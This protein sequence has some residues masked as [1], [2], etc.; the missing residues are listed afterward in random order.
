MPAKPAQPAAKKAAR[1]RPVTKPPTIAFEVLP[2]GTGSQHTATEAERQAFAALVATGST[3][4]AAYLAVRPK[5]TEVTAN[6]M[7]AKWAAELADQIQAMRQAAQTG[8]A[9]ALGVTQAYLVG[10]VKAMLETPLAQITADSIYC[11]KYKVTTTSTDAGPKTTVEVE[12]PCPLATVQA[13]AKL[14]GQA[15]PLP[16]T[17]Q[18]NAQDA[19]AQAEQAA[20]GRVLARIVSAGSPIARRLAERGGTDTEKAGG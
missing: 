15:E 4:K 9:L 5:V 13:L 1:S 6:A 20:I 16:L 12:K 19:E 2:A 17:E 18:A 3:Q 8:A 7:G 10:H 11:K 14:T